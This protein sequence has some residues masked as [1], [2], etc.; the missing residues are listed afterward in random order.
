VP[1]EA[2]DLLAILSTLESTK[3]K[4]D[5]ILDTVVKDQHQNTFNSISFNSSMDDDFN[6][7]RF[8]YGSQIMLRRN[9]FFI[10]I[11]NRASDYMS[12]TTMKFS[13]LCEPHA[14]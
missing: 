14:L 1:R 9:V 4:V 12:A 5:F 7:P 2:I 11:G 3:K 6:L 10:C 8:F 13:F